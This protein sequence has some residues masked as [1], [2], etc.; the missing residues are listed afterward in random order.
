[1]ETSMKVTFLII[2]TVFYLKHFP[3]FCFLH[4][5]GKTVYLLSTFRPHELKL[6]YST[7]VAFEK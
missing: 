3:R 5:F 1:M 4:I 6:K 2:K 7:G